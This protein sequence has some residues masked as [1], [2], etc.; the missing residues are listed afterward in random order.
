[1]YVKISI[2]FLICLAL[3]FM[4]VSYT[5]SIHKRRLLVGS[6]MTGL[7]AMGQFLPVAIAAIDGILIVPCVVGHI[8][9]F[10]LA[11]RLLPQQS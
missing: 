11:L 9:G 10:I 4:I 2:T 6:I 7:L 8:I 3:E 5:D 1:M